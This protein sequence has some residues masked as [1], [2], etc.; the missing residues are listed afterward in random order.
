MLLNRLYYEVKPWIPSRIRLALRRKLARRILNRSADVWPILESAAQKPADW[1][2]WPDAKQ[3][4]FSSSPTTSKAP[5]ASPMSNPSPRNWKCPSG[6]DPPSISSPK[7]LGPV[8]SASLLA[9]SAWLRSRRPRPPS[10]RQLFRSRDAFH[11][12]A[13]KYQ[14]LPRG[15]GTPSGSAPGSCSASS[16]GST[17]SISNTT[18]P[19]ST[20]TPSNPN[21]TAGRVIFPFWVPQQRPQD[22]ETTRPRDHQTTRPEDHSPVVPP[23]DP[24]APGS[25]SPVVPWSRGPSPSPLRGYLEL[26]YTL[27][28][29]ST[30]FLLLRESSPAIW[31]KNSIGSP[32][33]AVWRCSIHIRITWT[34]AK[35]DPRELFR[36]IV[37]PFP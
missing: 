14:S 33:T 6:S 27:P 19:P 3:F 7:A 35:A 26:P 21:P 23:S 22:Y 12:H 24:V 9:L 29:D 18:A 13:Q 2:G 37:L 17:I 1:P 16:I 10:R 20:P 25:R 34:L 31:I 36:R 8:S 32:P 11:R 30:L 28:Q 5:S 4:A 15:L